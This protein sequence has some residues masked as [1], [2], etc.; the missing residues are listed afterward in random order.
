MIV[1]E[2]FCLSD[3]N[4]VSGYYNHGRRLQ[5]WLADTFESESRDVHALRLVTYTGEVTQ[6]KTEHMLLVV[7]VFYC[8]HNHNINLVSGYLY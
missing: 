5:L 4:L 3:A 1:D 8:F 2:L 6:I 7:K